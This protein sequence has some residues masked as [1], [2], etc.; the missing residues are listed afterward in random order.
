MST[1]PLSPTIDLLPPR[2]PPQIVEREFP[3][4]VLPRVESDPRRAPAKRKSAK[5]V[6]S[7]VLMKS[8]TAAT[9]A[10]SF[11]LVSSLVGTVALETA[12]RTAQRSATRS[13]AAAAEESVLSRSVGR[14]RDGDA[15]DDWAAYN[16]FVS[17]QQA[18]PTK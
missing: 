15:I 11:Y 16:G 4:L 12:S 2:T 6:F 1:I 17:G 5:K 8:V 3:P 14:L 18:A 7:D 10:C 13:R 9:I